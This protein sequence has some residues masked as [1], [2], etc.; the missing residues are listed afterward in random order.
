MASIDHRN[1]LLVI[2]GRSKGRGHL[3]IFGS[4][5]LGKETGLFTRGKHGLGWVGCTDN[6]IYDG[7]ET[8]MTSE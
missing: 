5:E 4:F 8:A 1:V 7:E 3:N 2:R 6:A